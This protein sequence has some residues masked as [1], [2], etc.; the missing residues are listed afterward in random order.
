MSLRHNLMYYAKQVETRMNDEMHRLSENSKF[1][2]RKESQAIAADFKDMGYKVNT[3]F[4]SANAIKKEDFIKLSEYWKQKGYSTGTMQNKATILREILTAAKNFEAIVSNSE[5]GISK[6]RDVLN[7]ACKDKGCM[8]PSEA[9][10]SSI[11]DMAVLASIKLITAYGLRRDEALHAAWALSKGRNISENGN[12][13]LKGS[14]CKNGR[15]REFEMRDGGVALKETAALVKNIEINGRLEQFRGRL[16]RAFM[17]LKRIDN[18]KSLRPHSLRHNYIQEGCLSLTGLN[19]PV[20]GNPEYLDD[21][22]SLHPHA[23]RHNYAQERYLSITGF[24]APVKGGPKYIDMNPQEK[25][26]YDKACKI[27]S[28]ELGHSRESIAR[29][30]IGK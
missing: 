30:Y 22:E 8:P 6:D 27:I 15:P 23:L 11:K 1:K 9:A 7:A 16:D 28:E 19:A 4:S 20:K 17:E 26:L 25:S 21:N 29:T 10:L 2:I 24:N 13:K 14:W 3:K 18:N 12:L 5:L